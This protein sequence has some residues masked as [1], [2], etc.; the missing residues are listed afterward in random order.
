[1]LKK[2]FVTAIV[3]LLLSTL[4]LFIYGWHL[5][6]RIE[7]RFSARRWQIPS[8][9]YSDTTLIY[10][11]QR[12]SLTLLKNKLQHLGYRPVSHRPHRKGEMRLVA[13][14]AEIFLN[15]LKLPSQ[16]RPGFP[17]KIRI[18]GNHVESVERIDRHDF[19]P[20]LEL[21]P[22]EIGQFYGHERERRQLVSFQQV[23][24]HL[25]YAVLAAEDSRF[26]EHAGFDPLG[27]LRALIVNLLHGSIRQGGSTITQQL[28]KNYF[29]TPE[30][31]VS[32]KFNELMMSV[33]IELSYGKNE[34]LEI[35]LNEIYL[36]QKG[37]VAINGVG[38]ASYFYFGKAIGDI[39]L[40][41]A[42]TIAGLI[43]SP[44]HYSPY[45]DKKRCQE[46][47]NTVLRAMQTKNWI[48]EEQLFDSLALPVQVAGSSL[49]VKQ[50]P[51][52]MDYLT[53][54]LETL[55]S[56]EDLVSLG[57]SI[58]TTLDTRVQA[59][60]EWALKKGL[61]R[62]EKANPALKRKDPNRQL[63]GA[64]IVMQPKTGYVLAMVG[65]REYNVSQYNRIIQS[66]RQPGS[67]Y[68]PF[69]YLAAL[70]TLTAASRLSNAPET[71]M[72]NG[73]PWEPQN[74]SED[75]EFDVSVR[76]ALTKS[77]NRATVD[78]AMQVGLDRLVKQAGQ[79]HFTTPFKA[80]PSLALG[81]FE[82][83]P[84][85]LARAYCTFASG[86]ILPYPLSL[87][88]VA[89][90]NG[91]ILK[92]T[93]VNIKRLISSA[94]AF[95]ITDMLKSVATVGTARSIGNWGISG[96]VAGKTGTTSNYKD[97]WFVGYTPD[98][99]ALVWVGFDNGDSIS[100]TGSS[101]ALPIWADLM[102]AIPQYISDAHFKI[103]SGV[104]TRTVCSETGLL[105][106]GR[107]C[108]EPM[109]EYFLKGHEPEEYCPIHPKQGGLK[110][111][112]DG[113]KGFFKKE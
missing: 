33:I 87:K 35:Y 104:V 113:I 21:E 20:I 47:R 48:T 82:V 1:M 97:A 32:R 7:K 40:I 39:S 86:G 71:Y 106:A 10:P 62:L 2:L 78:L 17:V 49:P 24:D 85:E 66:R 76:T 84:V 50:A 31:T 6:M 25:V 11:G 56:P 73:K 23:P 54:Q 5:S 110:R 59:A 27:I 93:H 75:F 61:V 83:I 38:E 16:T 43:K 18:D 45:V 111:I 26:Y 30:R 9:V 64:I 99:L 89:D 108:P 44:G 92:Q 14:S 13:S 22:E 3:F 12:F 65:G 74:F 95:I 101:A 37:S 55:Y 112:I 81:A 36:G 29:L 42:A 34:I 79:F 19:L 4:G 52:F 109:E 100:A 8:T 91:N 67:A 102:K 69:I 28:A 57:L 46:R 41:E 90:E 72:V 98:I 15:D 53:R 96:I 94:K 105:S 103:P 58:Y 77:H 63:Q 70:D 51:Y 107:K 60:A 88:D 68:K 80:Y